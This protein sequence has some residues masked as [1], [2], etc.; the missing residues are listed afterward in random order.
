MRIHVRS[1]KFIERQIESAEAD[2][3]LDSFL[4]SA[5]FISIFSTFEAFE[6]NFSPFPDRDNVLKLQFDD[7]GNAPNEQKAIEKFHLIKFNTEMANKTFDFIQKILK[8]PFKSKEMFIHC[9]AGISRSG[10]FGRCLN[11]YFNKYLEMNHDH[12]EIFEIEHKNSICP[13]NFVYKIL[14]DKFFEEVNY[15]D[16]S[17]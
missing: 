1:R 7:I 4:S 9:D 17:I 3:R 15:S 5:S 16:V 12:S 14:K 6:K 11:E 13:N 2:G 8:S 10:A